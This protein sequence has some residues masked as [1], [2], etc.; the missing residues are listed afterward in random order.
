MN[1]DL[2][3]RASLLKEIEELKESPW[4]TNGKGENNSVNP[5]EAIVYTERMEAVEI[6]KSMCIKQ[7]PA[8]T[9]GVD[10]ANDSGWISVEEKPPMCGACLAIDANGNMCIT[11]GWQYIE[12]KKGR[13]FYVDSN[14]AS[15]FYDENGRG[16]NPEMRIC[17]YENRMTHWRPLP[18]P[19]KGE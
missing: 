4:C 6:I 10:L 16:K 7:A 14:L 15:R 17:I 2:I 18:K 5:I 19:P 8:V 12:D 13:Q 1:N 11:N 9:I 3:S